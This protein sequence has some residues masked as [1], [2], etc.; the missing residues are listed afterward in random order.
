MAPSQTNRDFAIYT[1][2]PNSSTTPT[3]DRSPF[4]LRLPAN[5]L[6]LLLLSLCLGLSAVG[7]AFEM[8]MPADGGNV[9]G[10]DLRVTSRYEDTLAAL[11]QRHGVGY[12]EVLQANPEV[13]AW[14]PGE[15]TEVI[16]PARFVLPDAPRRGIVINLPEYR[17]YYYAEDG[18]TVAT[19]P[20]GIG[21][22]EF[23]TPLFE[24]TVITRIEKPA[25]TPTPSIHREHIEAGDPLPRVVP[26]GPDNP[27]GDWA[28]QLGRPGYFIHGTNQPFGVGQR[29]S[30]GCIRLYP[31]HIEQLVT[32]AANGT[33]VKV[34]NQPNKLGRADGAL[35][36]E[37]HPRLDGTLDLT[38]MVRT[39]VGGTAGDVPEGEQPE[40]VAVEVDWQKAETIAR[41]GMGLPERISIN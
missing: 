40:R 17:L 29:V 9:V 23:A 6:G 21:R 35:Y 2:A 24:S 32:L 30:H 19:F 25:W 1:Y 11:A 7:N 20:V 28:I 31:T 41:E 22:E 38:G 27:L 26:P 36:L 39:V 10:K 3:V 16:I 33:P 4:R 12:L 18:S 8:P 34:V 15:G 14:L 37:S 13:D 5:R